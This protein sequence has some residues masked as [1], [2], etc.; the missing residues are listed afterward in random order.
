MN[1]AEKECIN[2]VIGDK[3]LEGLNGDNASKIE[4]LKG[5]MRYQR[6][7]AV[8]TTVI[9]AAISGGLICYGASM[10]EESR[11]T[12]VFYDVQSLKEASGML[13][14]YSGTAPAEAISG[15]L[16]LVEKSDAA[17][18]AYAK[19]FSSLEQSLNQVLQGGISGVTEP[20]IFQPA[21]DYLSSEVDNL[22]KEAGQKDNVAN[23]GTNLIIGGLGS[24]FMF[25]WGLYDKYRNISRINKLVNELEAGGQ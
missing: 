20:K 11:Q 8:I 16:E 6:T 15:A 12:P 4:T 7:R 1:M 17:N 13:A 25:G 24:G 5:M 23:G 22:V 18:A 3:E 19:E 14:S 10:R 21:M 9:C 2:L